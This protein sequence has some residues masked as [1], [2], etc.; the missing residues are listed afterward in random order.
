MPA[1][2]LLQQIK[3]Q[4]ITPDNFQ[5]YGQLIYAVSDRQQHAPTDTPLTKQT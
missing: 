3:A 1:A 2:R 4:Q 5:K